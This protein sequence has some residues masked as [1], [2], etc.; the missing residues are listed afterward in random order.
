MIFK[1]KFLNLL[2]NSDS[3]PWDFKVEIFP[4][5]NDIFGVLLRVIVAGVGNC[6]SMVLVVLQKTIC[7]CEM[8][9]M[10][11]AIFGRWYF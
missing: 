9:F 10:L 5:Q 1:S 6:C 2:Y 4:L 7:S 8:P 11:G 3:W